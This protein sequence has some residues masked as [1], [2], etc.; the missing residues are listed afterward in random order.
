MWCLELGGTLV[1]EHVEIK[2]AGLRFEY[3]TQYDRQL[4]RQWSMSGG[5]VVVASEHSAPRTGYSANVAVEVLRTSDDNQICAVRYSDIC[6][7]DCRDVD[8]HRPK[9]AMLT[10]SSLCSTA[11]Q[12]QLKLDIICRIATSKK[13]SVHCQL[14][15]TTSLNKP[16]PP[17]CL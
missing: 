9:M 17:S 4:L 5:R 3:L 12:R 7:P 8:R 13:T 2:H 14:H 10:V 16:T 1:M 15:T 11:G 6:T